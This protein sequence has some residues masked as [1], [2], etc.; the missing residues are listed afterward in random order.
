MAWERKNKKVPQLRGPV[1]QKR[2]G[3]TCYPKRSTRLPH[4]PLERFAQGLPA[5]QLPVHW[6]FVSTG[7]TLNEK[8]H[9]ARPHP[10]VNTARSDDSSGGACISSGCGSSSSVSGESDP[11]GIPKIREALQAMPERGVPRPRFQVFRQ[12]LWQCKRQAVGGRRPGAGGRG[13]PWVQ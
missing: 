7:H 2:V 3:Q 11:V 10:S 12:S 9:S 1:S 5:I 6:I 13:V 8:S 4:L